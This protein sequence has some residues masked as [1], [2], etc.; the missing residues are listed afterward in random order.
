M[1]VQE[2]FISN[3]NEIPSGENFVVKSLHDAPA[4][5]WKE[6]DLKKL[7]QLIKENKEVSNRACESLEKSGKSFA[8]K[9][10]K[11]DK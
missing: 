2:I 4:V 9:I 7:D 5:S 1:I 3:G 6:N 10:Q 11:K 8:K